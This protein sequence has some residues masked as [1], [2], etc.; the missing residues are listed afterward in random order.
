MSETLM[1]VIAVDDGGSST[2]IV[3]KDGLMEKFPSVK[4]YYGKERNLTNTQGKYDFIVEYKGDC[5]AAGSLAKYDC[6]LPLQMNTKSKQ[7]L[8]YDLSVLI[9]VHQY[10]YSDNHLVVSVPIRM[11]NPEE[12]NGRIERLKGKHTIK[13]NGYTK[14]FT[15]SDVRIAPETASAYWINEPKGKSRWL[16]IGSRTCGYATTINEDGI[17]RYID[18]ESGTFWGKGLEALDN[19]YDPKG[20]ADFICGNLIKSWDKDDNVYLLGGGALDS[21]LVDQIKTYFPN[22]QVMDNPQM[23]NALG[24]YQ[25]GKIAYQMA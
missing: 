22:A 8:F 18:T 5:Y 11:H 23:S 12:K 15:I 4:G 16:D 3:K 19:Q 2:C 24:M 10:G 9:A 17:N 1:G 21:A 25:L 20:L 7:H 13:V 14:T 6:A